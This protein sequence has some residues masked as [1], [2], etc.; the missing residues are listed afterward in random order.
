MDDQSGNSLCEIFTEQVLSV[1]FLL[2]WQ[3][4]GVRYSVPLVEALVCV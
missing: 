4:I 2:L 3:L 1:L